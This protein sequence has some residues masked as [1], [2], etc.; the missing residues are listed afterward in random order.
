M[1]QGRVTKHRTGP[2]AVLP[3]SRARGLALPG[4]GFSKLHLDK[5]TSQLECVEL[6]AE[7]W[8][9]KGKESY[10]ILAPSLVHGFLHLQRFDCM[11][12][13]HH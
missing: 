6:N 12:S 4:V 5:T 13:L 3:G 7:N 11:S 2:G 8:A 9:K 1:E 10:Y